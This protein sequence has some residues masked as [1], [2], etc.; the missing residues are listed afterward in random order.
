METRCLWVRSEVFDHGVIPTPRSSNLSPAALQQLVATVKSP[1]I[2]SSQW[3]EHAQQQLHLTQA[4]ASVYLELYHCFRLQPLT[5]IN[6]GNGL[7]TA[8]DL[9]EL[10]LFIFLQISH[11]EVSHPN[12][13][14]DDP[15]PLAQPHEG[16]SPDGGSPRSRERRKAHDADR[17]TGRLSFVKSR[18]SELLHL[19]SFQGTFVDSIKPHQLDLSLIHI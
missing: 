19:A 2:T 8:V 3:I 14:V 18:L 9:L 10:V 16:M 4:Q 7:E 12:A 5:R 17:S 1:A 13:A 6:T 15:W 11:R